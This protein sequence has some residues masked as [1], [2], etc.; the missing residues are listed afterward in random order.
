MSGK[1]AG[2]EGI[3]QEADW[4]AVVGFGSE[5]SSQKP[6]VW[7]GLSTHVLIVEDEAGIREL[8]LIM[9]KKEGFQVTAVDTGKAALEAV[10][11]GAV[12]VVLADF[13]LPDIDGISLL[14]SLLEY[15]RRIMGIVMTGYGT[16]DLAVKAMKAGA[17]DVLPK[18]F[19]PDQVLLVLRRALE[20]QRL[21]YENGLLKQAVLKGTGVRLQAFRLQDINQPKPDAARGAGEPSSSEIWQLA[22]QRG[23]IEG[24][25]R[26]REREAA[27]SARRQ[28]LAASLVA[29][30]GKIGSVFPQGLEDQVA[31]LAFKIACK[32]VRDCAEEKRDL[33]LA[34]AREALARVRESRSV[35]IRVNPRDLPVLE[36]AREALSELFEGPVTMKLEAEASIS[37]GGCLVET[38]TRLID[39]TIEAQ[40]IQ[41]GEALRRRG[42]HEP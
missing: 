40:L 31:A 42:R 23:L 41:L 5:P 28:T 11:T 14:E 10:Q 18:P 39:A 17:V 35:E 3:G 2:V 33:V 16:I 12:R 4:S 30:L 13:K 27:E 9:L 15:D 25:R 24:E 8:L 32:V 21:Q 29:Q 20:M 6:Y 26:A 37:P 19:A 22:Y 34:Q 1:Q 38:P 36:A 7:A